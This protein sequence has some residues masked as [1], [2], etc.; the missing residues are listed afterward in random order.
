MRLADFRFEPSRPIIFC[1]V[2]WLERER[3]L[4]PMSP[5]GGVL[6]GVMGSL[7]AGLEGPAESSESTWS[8]L[9]VGLLLACVE[10]R[11]RFGA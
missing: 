6:G 10:G 1:Q 7:P 11:P 5:E 9:P 3:G 2:L 4:W 8:P